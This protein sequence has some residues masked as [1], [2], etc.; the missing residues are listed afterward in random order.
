[1]TT[2]PPETMYAEFRRAAAAAGDAAAGRGR[3]CRRTV[4]L[5]APDKA[6]ALTLCAQALFASAEV[7]Q[8]EKAF[9]ALVAQRPG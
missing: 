9:A 2:M 3:S 8:A 5:A 7:G 1:M 6:A 4:V